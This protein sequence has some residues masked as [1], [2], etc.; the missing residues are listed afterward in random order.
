VEERELKN[1]YIFALVK[2]FLFLLIF[3][4]L[5]EIG[6]SFIR[7][8]RATK[9]LSFNVFILSTL[10]TF[11]FYIFIFDLGNFYKK[12]QK[13]FFRSRF[14]SCL[15]PSGLILFAAGYFFLPKIFNFSVKG[16][17]FVFAG[18]FSLIAH[19]IYVS[20]VTRGDSFV[21]IVNY[22]FIFSIFFLL[23]LILFGF[24]L[25]IIFDFDLGKVL[26]SGIQN[27]TELIRYVF[28]RSFK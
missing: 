10:I 4:F 20:R 9:G 28:L 26:F 19:L 3:C 24:Y 2:L 7:E 11:A 16:D 25:R 13:F 15:F 1:N 8:F 22:F 6:R 14:F 27:G 18:T 5:T 21:S 12:L 17:I 23:N